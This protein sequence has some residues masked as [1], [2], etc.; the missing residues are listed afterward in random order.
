MKVMTRG[1]CGGMHENPGRPC[2][3]FFSAALVRRSTMRSMKRSE[4]M[5]AIG[6]SFL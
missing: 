6:S 1:K 3:L 4:S 2:W 5:G